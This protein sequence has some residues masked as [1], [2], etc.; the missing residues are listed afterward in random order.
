[1]NDHSELDEKEIIPYYIRN[2]SYKSGIRLILLDIGDVF[3]LAS[4]ISWCQCLS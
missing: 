4:S 2:E 1:M 3:K